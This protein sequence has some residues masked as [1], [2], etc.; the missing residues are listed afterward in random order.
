MYMN[1]G[2]IKAIWD[3]LTYDQKL[4]ATAFIFKKICEHAKE[5]GSFQYLIYDRL[6]FQSD[7][8]P[9]LYEARGINISNEF[10]LEP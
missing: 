7:A 10:K 8:Y 4:A 2:W 1:A 6:G 3:N 5:G 9:N